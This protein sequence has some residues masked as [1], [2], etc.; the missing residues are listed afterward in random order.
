MLRVA[1]CCNEIAE[2]CI[3]MYYAKGN[4]HEQRYA[5]RFSAIQGCDRSNVG[6]G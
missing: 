2:D 3:V 6:V 5:K 4:R 1:A